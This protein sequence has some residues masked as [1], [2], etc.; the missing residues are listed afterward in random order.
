MHC[1]TI[2]NLT[3]LLA[4][5]LGMTG[6]AALAQKA[7]AA[8]G[9]GSTPTGPS[10]NSRT[11]LPP[12]V[13]SIPST[14]N[15]P[16]SASQPIFLSGRVQ[17]DDGTPPSYEIRIERVCSGNARL[18]GHADS[19]GRFTIQL[20]SNSEIDT[21]AADSGSG[22]DFNQRNN[23]GFSPMSS[24]VGQR[25]NSTLWNCELRASYPGYRSDLV[26]LGN[27]RPMD[28]PNLGTI[29]LHRLAEVKG[30]T[31]S[32]TTAMAPKPAHKSYEK[33]LEAAKKGK[34]EEAEKQL[35]EATGVYPKF[36]LAWF[37]L[38][39]VQQRQNEAGAARK[40][41][42]AAIA[43]DSKYVSP[44]EQLALLAA[45]E[46][47]WEEAANYS[48]QAVDLNPV[49]FPGAFWYG[50]IANYNLKK[51][52]EAEKSANA[53]VKLDTTHRYP[54][55]QKML[56]EIALEKRDYADAATHLRTYLELAPKAKD[57]D[58]LKQELLKI[59][60]ARTAEKQ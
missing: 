39:Q 20:G 15:P 2:R 41:Y 52:P 54:G 26:E 23:G 16:P 17:F 19:K 32:L 11:T 37:A 31:I 13:N 58:A 28:D 4:I 7:P 45:Q 36:A 43:A 3:V 59:E 53:L 6:D 42:Q 24:S 49:E 46:A 38:G 40:S 48:K 5:G 14:N 1:W 44:Y 9:S 55:A 21:S 29:V 30:S 22:F 10:G 27:R 34:F 56:A 33:G 57:A 25:G 50:A 12:S 60:E 47:N 8:P 51:L 35:S 18:E